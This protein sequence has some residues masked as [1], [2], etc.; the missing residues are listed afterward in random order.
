MFELLRQK[1]D[2]TDDQIIKFQWLADKF[3]AEWIELY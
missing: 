2:F 1:E 3:F